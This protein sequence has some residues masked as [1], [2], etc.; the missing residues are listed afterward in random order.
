MFIILYY[1]DL[2]NLQKQGNITLPEEKAII[3]EI[4]ELE[5][6]LPYAAPLEM[7]TKEMEEARVEKKKLGDQMNALFGQ[8]EKLQVEIDEL[9]TDLDN[10]RKVL[11]IKNPLF[12][13]H[14]H[15][16]FKK[17]LKKLQLFKKKKI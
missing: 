4:A 12:F 14:H 9:R 13:L 11:T 1:R 3:K 2:I 15:Q 16:K 5:K 8:K 7:V 10:R 6:C 17:N